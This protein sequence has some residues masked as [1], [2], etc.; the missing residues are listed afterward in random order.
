MIIEVRITCDSGMQDTLLQTMHQLATTPTTLWQDKKKKIR[1]VPHIVVIDVM[2][3][4]Q[5]AVCLC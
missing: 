3:Y 1:R 2:H 4:N 5:Q